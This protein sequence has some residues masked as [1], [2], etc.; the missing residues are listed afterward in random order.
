MSCWQEGALTKGVQFK[1]FFPIKEKLG[2]PNL[3]FR[4]LAVALKI[5]C[6]MGEIISI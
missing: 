6:V 4:Q 5:S 1:G 2:P 3:Y